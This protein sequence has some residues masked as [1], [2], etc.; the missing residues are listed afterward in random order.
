MKQVQGSRQV[1]SSEVGGCLHNTAQHA[2]QV[3]G[4]GEMHQQWRLQTAQ[5]GNVLNLGKGEGALC[6]SGVLVDS[7]P[8]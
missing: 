1:K 4:S 6:A 7:G 2:P 3:G 5:M 8:Q